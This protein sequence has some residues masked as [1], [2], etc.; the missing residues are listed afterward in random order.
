MAGGANTFGYVG[1]NPIR[2][3]D[4]WGLDKIILLPKDDPNYPAAEKIPDDPTVC[5][6]ISHGSSRTVNRMGAKKLNRFLAKRCKPKQPVKLDACSAGAG[7]DSIAEQLAKLR[8]T[9]V[10][11]PDDR[12]WTT[13]WDSEMDTPLPPMSEDKDSF[14]NSV[15]NV[16]DPGQWRDFGPDGPINPHPPGEFWY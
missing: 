9:K 11:A 4:P 3:I 10:T 14:W 12:I 2:Y 13:P 1:G 16:L 5:L 6:V 15:P 8:K 7:E